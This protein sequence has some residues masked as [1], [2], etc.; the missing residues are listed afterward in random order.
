MAKSPVSLN[1]QLKGPWA[2]T[3]KSMRSLANKLEKAAKPLVTWASRE[4]LKAYKA[5]YRGSRAGLKSGAII[6]LSP[7]TKRWRQVGKKVGRPGSKTPWAVP[8]SSSTIP[9]R[10]TGALASGLEIY[11]V[12]A[13]HALVRFNPTKRNPEGS[14]TLEDVAMM[15]E[16]DRIVTY[17]VSNRM[18]AYFAVLFRGAGKGGRPAPPG[19]TNLTITIKFPGRPTF[20]TTTEYLQATL[21]PQMKK[22]VAEIYDKL[23]GSPKK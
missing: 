16:V 20:A 1:V 6:P 23:F 15:Q 22:K 8:Q 4:A 17:H 7:N 19:D 5:A 10:R 21:I 12:S 18:R 3:S 2:E 13:M 14:K 11:R 9:L